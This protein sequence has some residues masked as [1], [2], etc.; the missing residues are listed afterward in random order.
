MMMDIDQ[1][2]QAI[3]EAEIEDFIESDNQPTRAVC[4]STASR[5]R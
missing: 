2:T 4:G 1:A 5:G 3:R